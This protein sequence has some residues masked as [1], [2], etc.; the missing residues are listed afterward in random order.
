MW[1]CGCISYYPAY[2]RYPYCCFILAGAVLYMAILPVSSLYGHTGCFIS[3]GAV[4]YMAILP[5]S[6]LYGHTACFISVWPYC[7]FHLCMAILPVSSLYGHTAC[8]ISVWP[9]CLAV[10]SLYGH[11]AWLFHLCWCC[12]LYSHCLMNHLPNNTVDRYM[13]I[14]GPKD[15]QIE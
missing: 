6:F 4:L 7:L 3:A 13:C 9:Y 5:V 1:E 11:T 10:S 2:L 15:R 8:F 14:F 12:P